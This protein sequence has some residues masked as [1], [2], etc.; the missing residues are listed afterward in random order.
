M[1][2][3]CHKRRCKNDLTQNVLQAFKVRIRGVAIWQLEI[4]SSKEDNR[5]LETRCYSERRVHF[6]V[7]LTEHHWCNAM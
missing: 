5:S 6:H 7:Y 4:C 1:L 2:A 3:T